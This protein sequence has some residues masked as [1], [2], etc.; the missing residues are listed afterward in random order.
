MQGEMALLPL[1]LGSPSSDIVTMYSLLA[2]CL[3]GNLKLAEFKTFV[4]PPHTPVA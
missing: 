1:A 4:K 3:F 2:F